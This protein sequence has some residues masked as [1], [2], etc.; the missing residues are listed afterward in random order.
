MVEDLA[1][2][3]GIPMPKICIAQ[4][5]VPNAFAFGRGRHDGRVCVTRGIMELLNPEEL[6]AVLGHELT[7]IKNRDVITITLLSVIPMIMYRIAWHFMFYGNRRSDDRHP[8][9]M[10]I[11]MVALVFYFITNL[12]VMYASSPD[13]S[14]I[15]L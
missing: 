2:R 4:I 3:A 14:L 12:L 1:R 13:C 11:G 15:K 10:M 9:G 8:S 7:H 5:P 6:R